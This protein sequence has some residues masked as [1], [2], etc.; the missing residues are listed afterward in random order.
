MTGLPSFVAAEMLE[1]KGISPYQL[2]IFRENFPD[3]ME[4]T[5]EN[6]LKA[7]EV[8]FNI[9][10]LVEAFAPEE[11]KGFNKAIVSILKEFRENTAFAFEEYRSTLDSAGNERKAAVRFAQ[12]ARREAIVP[13]RK[14]RV[15]AIVTTLVE[16]VNS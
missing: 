11:V 15:L 10:W 5:V 3:G 7:L 8:N 6:L 4:V 13:H 14:A 1:S 12:E 16:L 2:R 9:Y